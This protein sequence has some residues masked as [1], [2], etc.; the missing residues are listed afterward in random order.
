MEYLSED[1]LR[2]LILFQR[3]DMETWGTVAPL[4]STSYHGYLKVSHRYPKVSR[5]PTHYDQRP[6]HPAY[7]RMKLFPA[8]VLVNPGA[9]C[10]I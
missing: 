7:C 2:G 10:D 8:S 6:L 9:R 3:P 4:Y 5:R 1:V